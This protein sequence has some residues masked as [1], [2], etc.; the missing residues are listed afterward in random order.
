MDNP[1][2]ELTKV[3]FFLSLHFSVKKA[4]EDVKKCN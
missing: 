1:T 3:G 4:I 2:L